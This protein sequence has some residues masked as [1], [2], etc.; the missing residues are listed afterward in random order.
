MEFSA[1]NIG[2]CKDFLFLWDLILRVT[3]QTEVQWG[4]MEMSYDSG[5]LGIWRFIFN[6]FIMPKAL[7][8]VLVFARFY[9]LMSRFYI[10][11][12]LNSS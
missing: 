11:L 8:Y 10:L 7:N 5:W 2:N 6:Y 4:K 3:A 1:E 9:I 12:V